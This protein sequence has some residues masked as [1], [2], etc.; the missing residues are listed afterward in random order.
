V[1]LCTTGVPGS[2][3]CIHYDVMLSSF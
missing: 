1:K 3:S 2:F